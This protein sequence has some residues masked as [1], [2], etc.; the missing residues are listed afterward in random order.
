MI[1]PFGSQDEASKMCSSLKAAGGTC[2]V[3]RI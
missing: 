1:G 2:F 3:Q